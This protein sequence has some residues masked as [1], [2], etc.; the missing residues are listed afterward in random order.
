MGRMRVRDTAR[1]RGQRDG[2]Q[3]SAQQPRGHPARTRTTNPL[4]V[5]DWVV[6]K[7]PKE[8]YAE[9]LRRIDNLDEA[10]RPYRVS[11]LRAGHALIEQPLRAWGLTGPIPNLPAYAEDHVAR[12]TAASIVSTY[13]DAHPY[14]PRCFLPSVQIIGVPWETLPNGVHVLDLD[15]ALVR[16]ALTKSPELKDL[17][18]VSE[19][20][21]LALYRLFGAT[22][23]LIRR[24]G[25]LALF[26]QLVQLTLFLF[27]A[28][29]RQAPTKD[30]AER[31][32]DAADALLLEF[33]PDLSRQMT[34]TPERLTQMRQAFQQTHDHAIEI[35][36]AL[37]MTGV[38]SG[39]LARARLLL[40]RRVNQSDLMRWQRMTVHA[41]AVDAFTMRHR[42]SVKAVRDQLRLGEKADEIGRTWAEFVTFLGG[43]PES[44][45]QRILTALSP[46]APPAP[47]PAAPSAK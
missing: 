17:D 5:R 21:T 43:R 32:A 15:P 37:E 14:R 6:E 8:I 9:L 25:P 3:R 38:T 35:R 47:P 26:N 29:A 41:V 24:L 4:D 7:L 42:L 46:P 13:W 22:Q 45:Q 40:G 20:P 31:A 27:L 34:R 16:I 10:I 12:I 33:L 30:A 19:T 23:N 18:R 44:E 11:L 36:K 28:T 1:N 39:I 2:G